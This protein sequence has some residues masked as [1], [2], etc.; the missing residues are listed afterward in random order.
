MRKILIALVVIVAVVAAGEWFADGLAEDTIEERLEE[1]TGAE[2][3]ADV[4]SFPLLT[5]TLLT[6]R[7]RSVEI[8]LVD[9]V[10]EEVRFDEINVD[11][12]GI[13]LP[14]GRLFDGD[15]R[16]TAIDAGTVGAFLSVES[17]GE[18]LGVPLGELDPTTVSAELEGGNLTVEAPNIGAQ[19]VPFPEDVMPCSA[20]G[21]VE[22]E[23]VRLRCAIDAIPQVVLQHVP[24]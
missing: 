19:S 18:A 11:V 22:A 7:V 2:A 5:G 3:T 12:N 21:Q 13:H 15:F 16:P 8:T 1:E 14:R 10:T 17:L 24:R 23:G 4:S 6:E 9:L 20:S